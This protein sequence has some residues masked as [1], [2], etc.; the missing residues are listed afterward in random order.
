MLRGGGWPV[1]SLAND[2]GN[3]VTLPGNVD[4]AVTGAGQIVRPLDAVGSS[5][6]NN[7][8]VEVAQRL[9]LWHRASQRVAVYF[10]SAVVR[11]AQIPAN[12]WLFASD[13][14]TDVQRLFREAQ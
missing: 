13:N 11:I 3:D 5:R 1:G 10:Q 12:G 9:A 6:A 4:F 2:A 8:F 14:R 7:H